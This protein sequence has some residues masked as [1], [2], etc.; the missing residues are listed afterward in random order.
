[1]TGQTVR[2]RAGLDPVHVLLDG[3]GI[4]SAAREPEA[5]TVIPD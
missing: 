3:P 5:R 2:L 1:M 4:T